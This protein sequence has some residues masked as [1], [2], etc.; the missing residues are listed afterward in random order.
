MIE[1]RI[2]RWGD[3]PGLSEWVQCD[4]KD[5]YKREARG[6]ANSRGCDDRIHRMEW[7]EEGAV[8]QGM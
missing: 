4:P 5:R 6:S 3:Q 7:W 1:L 2:L 8:S